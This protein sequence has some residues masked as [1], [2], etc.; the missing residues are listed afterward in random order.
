MPS[1]SWSSVDTNHSAWQ[2]GWAV[3]SGVSP[4]EGGPITSYIAPGSG[5]HV[6]RAGGGAIEVRSMTRTVA[7]GWRTP[8][9][10][11]PRAA[12][13]GPLG[14]CTWVISVSARPL[15]GCVAVSRAVEIDMHVGGGA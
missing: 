15:T 6:V 8:R 10:T 14:C 3:R 13:R 7:Q 4:V 2:A 11:V 9:Q 12:C 1:P 5:G